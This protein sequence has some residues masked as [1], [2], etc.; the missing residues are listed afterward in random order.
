M[1][2]CL[3]VWSYISL[4][5]ISRSDVAEKI[6]RRLASLSDASSSF[7]F[8]PSL[9]CIRLFA[10]RWGFTMISA[11]AQLFL[12]FALS[13]GCRC[14]N[15]FASSF[16]GVRIPAFHRVF[17]PLLS[18]SLGRATYFCTALKCSQ[19]F[20]FDRASALAYYPT[21]IVMRLATSPN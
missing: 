10:I 16:L 2:H 11:E 12:S 4:P 17:P 20:L 5:L 9:L 13:L 1:F 7:S 19:L 14:G 3:R 6:R 8:L 21:S 15:H 18:F